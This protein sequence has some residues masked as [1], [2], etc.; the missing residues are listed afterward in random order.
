MIKSLGKNWI[1]TNFPFALAQVGWG[2]LVLTFVLTSTSTTSAQTRR[3]AASIPYSYSEQ[4]T[5]SATRPNPIRLAQAEQEVP[6][7]GNLDDDDSFSPID[8]FDLPNINSNE[9]E[10]THD[11]VYQ[12]T[13]ESSSETSGF[14]IEEYLQ[15]SDNQS[16]RQ[17]PS[18]LDDEEEDKFEI[19]IPPLRSTSPSPR[20]NTG[21]GQ[22]SRLPFT[23]PEKV[24]IEDVIGEQHP[25]EPGILDALRKSG[26]FGPTERVPTPVPPERTQSRPTPIPQRPVDPEP[27]SP[28][29]NVPTTDQLTGHDYGKPQAKATKRFF[30]DCNVGRDMMYDDQYGYGYPIEIAPFAGFF[31]ENPCAPL[32]DF[33]GSGLDFFGYQRHCPPE[34]PCGWLFDHMEVFA[35][36]SGFGLRSDDIE[37]TSFGLHEG[38]NWAGSF[39]PRFGLAAQFG[40]RAVQRTVDGKNPLFGDEEKEW[41][42]N[43]SQ[44]F[45][46]TGLFKRAQCHPLQYGVVYDWMSDNI[47]RNRQVGGRTLEVF[48]LG[49]VRTELSLRCCSGFT[50]GF[51]G[52]FGTTQ[53][54][55]FSNVAYRARATT[56]LHGFFEKPFWCGSLV[57]FSAG[58]TPKGNAILSTYYDQPLRDKFS[59]KAGFTYML[60]QGKNSLDE[61]NAWEAAI[62]LT[63][64]PHGGAFTKNGNPLRAMFDVAGNGS[65][66]VSHQK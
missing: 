22:P 19:E 54:D 30:R 32:F 57:G 23:I 56:Q 24:S 35:G 64:H 51:R 60:P 47:Y 43:K 2:V 15:E 59:L 48:N 41:N 3:S 65:M 31:I 14:D 45:I 37:E 52:A 27:T 5:F 63:F 49:Q 62:T 36:T 7:L 44:V 18:F 1:L 58:G 50:W 20:Q 55:V 46:T 42:G 61:R 33:G 13:L 12:D 21:T 9:E 39:S 53:S 28:I 40:V 25:D 10:D 4:S 8:G 16:T 6:F 17:S 29:T 34:R 66:I 11:Q 26:G 38:I